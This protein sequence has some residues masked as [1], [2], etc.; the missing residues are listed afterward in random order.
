[1]SEPVKPP[2]DEPTVTGLQGQI[3]ALRLDLAGIIV[4]LPDDQKTGV[5]AML[6]QQAGAADQANADYAAF[7]VGE[8]AVHNMLMAFRQLIEA[9]KQIEAI[10]KT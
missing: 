7:S 10:R 5:L 9:T 4:M 2:P 8:E 1:M 6:Q 3:L